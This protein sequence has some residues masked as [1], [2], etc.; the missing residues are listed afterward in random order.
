MSVNA[1]PAVQVTIV[2]PAVNLTPNPL[3]SGGTPL[4]CP[5]GSV[6]QDATLPAATSSLALA[7]PVGVTTAVFVFVAAVTATDL[8]VN[9]GGTPFALP[10]PLG[11]GIMLYNITSAHV[12]LSSALGG[13]IQYAVGG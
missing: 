10:V 3:E 2:D 11:Q 8:V 12:S 4:Y 1:T 5:N 6:G 7:F 9:V 13:K